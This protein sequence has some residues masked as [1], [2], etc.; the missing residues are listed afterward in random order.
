MVV[1]AGFI[2][3]FDSEKKSVANETI[4]CI[5]AMSISVC[6]VGLLTALPGTQLTRRLAR[7]GRLH[8]GHDVLFETAADFAISRD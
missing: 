3:G 7:E 1:Y 4:D 2:V 8:G 6:M 5:E